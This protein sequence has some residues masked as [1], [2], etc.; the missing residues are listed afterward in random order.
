M[1]EK[2]GGI[3]LDAI[4]E[5]DLALEWLSHPRSVQCASGTYGDLNIEV[6]D[7]A[8]ILLE[9]TNQLGS[10]HLDSLRPERSRTYELIGTE[11]LIRWMA[12]GK[13]PEKSTVEMYQTSS[14][15]WEK[16]K[17]E[18]TLNDMYTREIDHF[19]DCVESGEDPVVGA[20]KGSDALQTAHV[21]KEAAHTGQRKQ[22]QV[23]CY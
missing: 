23:E 5:I 10:V 17:Y 13:S 18:L 7:T 11:G 12:R 20:A 1:S 16:K 8:E 21:A 22:V 14:D 15:A 3:I 4:H 9:G 2:G 6:E 19:L